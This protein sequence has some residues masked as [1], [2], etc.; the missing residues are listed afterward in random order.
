MLYHGVGP[1]V[2][3]FNYLP[4]NYD[5]EH[6]IPPNIDTRKSL[7]NTRNRVIMLKQQP[8]PPVP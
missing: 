2:A 7:T 1:T 6:A 5:L 4:E 3:T 8:A